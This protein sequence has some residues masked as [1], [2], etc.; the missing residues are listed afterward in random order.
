MKKSHGSGIF[1]SNKLV[2]TWK[3][4]EQGIKNWTFPAFSRFHA[5]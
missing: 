5:R 4:P 3:L 1:M 2:I